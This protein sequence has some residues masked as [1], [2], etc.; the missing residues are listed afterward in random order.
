MVHLATLLEGSVAVA[1]EVA[2]DAFLSVSERWNEIDRPDAYLRTSVVDRSVS[3]LRR[4]TTIVLTTAA[5]SRW[6][7]WRAW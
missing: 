7:A 5:L 1:E 4:R 6:V 2:Q 3:A